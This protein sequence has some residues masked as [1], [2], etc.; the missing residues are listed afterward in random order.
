MK[1]NILVV[2]HLHHAQ[3][4]N[5]LEE[6]IVQE[7]PD[8][9]IFLGD[10]FDSWFDYDG[11][12]VRRANDTAVWLKQSLAQPNRIHLFGNHD[13]PYAFPKNTL[14]YCSG[15]E[16]PKLRVIE[17]ILEPSDWSRLLLAHWEGDVLFT[18]AGLSREHVPATISDVRQWLEREIQDAWDTIRGDHRRHWVVRVGS[19]RGGDE[20]GP[21]GLTWCDFDR[22]FQPVLG[23]RQIFGHTPRPV[24]GFK[25]TNDSWNACFDIN[26]G[27]GVDYYAVWDGA[28]FKVR[29]IDGQTKRGWGWPQKAAPKPPRWP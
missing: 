5:A 15:F 25:V 27:G 24:P 21:G 2:G 16:E 1:P 22:E 3:N 23:L 13:L 8:R 12:G 14:L 9:I 4:L 18:H 29:G 11:S 28:L 19:K 6:A 17:S 20:P 7:E 10:Y 26:H